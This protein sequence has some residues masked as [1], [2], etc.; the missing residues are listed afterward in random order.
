M[1]DPKNRNDGGDFEKDIERLFDVDEDDSLSEMDVAEAD[2][3]D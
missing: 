1:S 3:E 2:E